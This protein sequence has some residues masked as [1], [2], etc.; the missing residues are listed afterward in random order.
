MSQNVALVIELREL[1]LDTRY[2]T[3]PRTKIVILGRA[4]EQEGRDFL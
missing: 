2:T 4:D 3:N 1:K